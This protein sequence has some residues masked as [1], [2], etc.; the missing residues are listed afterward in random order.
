MRGDGDCCEWPVERSAR[1][2]ESRCRADE[3]VGRRKYGTESANGTTWVR[4]LGG[5]GD[6]V[7]I[8]ELG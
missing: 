8:W 6:W 3:E 7:G 5:I 2:I 1:D 4:Y